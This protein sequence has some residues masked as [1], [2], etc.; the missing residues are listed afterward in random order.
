M[1]LVQLEKLMQ[2]PYALRIPKFWSKATAEGETDQGKPLRF[3]CWRSS[4]ISQDDAHESAL[5]VAKRIIDA[6]RSGRNLRRYP[7]G[8]LPLRE[9]VVN[10]LKD[11]RG[12]LFAAVTRNSFGSLVLNAE[13]VMFVDIDFPLVFIG[14]R[15]THFFVRLFGLGKTS[16]EAKR[17]E[18]AKGSLEHFMAQHPGWG[19]RLYRTFAGFRGIVTH[20]VF[21]PKRDH[22]ID[23]LRQMGSDPLY[24]RLCRSQECFRARLTPKPWRC[25][26]R[27]NTIRYPIEDPKVAER[28]EQWK[29]NY[30][31]CQSQYA[32]CRF[33]NQMG[34]TAVH[35][36]VSQVVELHDYLTRC[37]ES[38]KLA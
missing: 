1:T 36:E 18:R 17:E 34:N 15:I 35:P 33:V 6:L 22:A 14:E 21:D 12:N 32:T 13:R 37:N 29:T 20:D 4:D 27:N 28:F 10:K 30:E 5:S 19:L 16:P 25:G 2:E 9:E 26:H 7:Y 11:A 38:L 8:C 31:A 24:V 3:S 23:V